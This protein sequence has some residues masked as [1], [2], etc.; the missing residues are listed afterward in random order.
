MQNQQG[1]IS[2]QPYSL[3]YGGVSLLLDGGTSYEQY[4][5]FYNLTMTGSTICVDNAPAPSSAGGNSRDKIFGGFCNPQRRPDSVGIYMTEYTD[6]LMTSMAINNASTCWAFENAHANYIQG[7]CEN[8]NAPT[9]VQTCNGGVASQ[10]C[11]NADRL[12]ADNGGRGYGNYFAGIM[13]YRDDTALRIDSPNVINT[14]FIGLRGGSFMT[15]HSYMI[16]GVYGCPGNG[17]GAS[18]TILDWDCI[19]TQVAVTV[20]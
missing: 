17:S 9:V 12:T 11:I 19:H 14:T 10:S 20:N 16:N 1:T 15:T 5:E 3:T 13:A 18:V 7:E 8:D 2:A 4:S 6:T